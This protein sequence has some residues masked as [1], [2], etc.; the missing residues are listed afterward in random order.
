MRFVCPVEFHPLFGGE[1][2]RCVD[3]GTDFGPKLLDKHATFV[4]RW[5]LR[6]GGALLAR[7]YFDKLTIPTLD[8]LFEVIDAELANADLIASHPFPPPGRGSGGRKT[9][10]ACGRP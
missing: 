7:L 1:P 9:R 8:R 2:F 3:S 10:R 5:G 6:W 4:A